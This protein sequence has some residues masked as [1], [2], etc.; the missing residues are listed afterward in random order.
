M[1]AIAEPLTKYLRLKELVGFSRLNDGHFAWVGEV[2]Q[3]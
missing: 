1:R 2:T 3:E